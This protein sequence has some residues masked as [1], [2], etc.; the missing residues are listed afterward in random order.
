MATPAQ[1]LK[2]IQDY[3][4]SNSGSLPTL[5]T[6]TDA[7]IKDASGKLLVT[8]L[9]LAAINSALAS[10]SVTAAQLNNTAAIA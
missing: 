3:A 5:N 1:A 8:S 7:G 2:Q 10:T 6:Y 9:N 4:N